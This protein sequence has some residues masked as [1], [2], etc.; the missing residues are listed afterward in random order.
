LFEDEID[1]ENMNKSTYYDFKNINENLDQIL[2]KLDEF[3][4]NKR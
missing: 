2:F 1:A 3:V 4:L